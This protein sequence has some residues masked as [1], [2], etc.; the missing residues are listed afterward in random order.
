[1][2]QIFDAYGKQYLIGIRQALAVLIGQE[3]T[4]RSTD[5]ITVK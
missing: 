4:A 1:M 2:L 5:R 3:R